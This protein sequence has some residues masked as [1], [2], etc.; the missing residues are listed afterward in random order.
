[1][2]GCTADSIPLARAASVRVSRVHWGW[3]VLVRGRQPAGLVADRPARRVGTGEGED[4]VPLVLVDPPSAAGS[5]PVAQHVEALGVGPGQAFTHGLP[6]AAQP[7]GDGAGPLAV[8]AGYDHP[9][10]HGPVTGSV[11]RPASFRILRFSSAS[12][13]GR[14]YNS[15]GM[16]DASPSIP[17]TANDLQIQ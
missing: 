12:E 3:A 5:G 6:V 14:A 1:M 8:P 4:A 17:P 2:R 16:K 10:P 7:G 15:V 13:G 11:P 9:D